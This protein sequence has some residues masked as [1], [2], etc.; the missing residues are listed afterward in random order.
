MQQAPALPTIY[1]ID[2]SVAVTGAFV[3][4][5]N[6]AR[7]LKD[8]ARVV[9]VL[10]E[11]TLITRAECCDFWRVEHI[12]AASL[13]KNPAAL[14]RYLPNVLRGGL[15]VGRLMRNDTSAHLI[16]ND[17]YVMQGIVLRLLGYR[18][19]IV[20]L[21]RCDPR[22]FAGALAPWMLWMQ[23]ISADRV[24]AVS[25]HVRSLLPARVKASV[26]YDYFS[27]SVR[28]PVKHTT[29]GEKRFVYIGNYIA[30]KGQDMAL[31]AFAMVAKNDPSLSLH[32]YGGDMGLAKNR[33]YRLVL[34]ARAH[35]VGLSARIHFHDFVAD[36][37]A[38]L[39]TGFAALNFSTSESFSMTVLEASGCGL[40]V[41][42]TLS[43]GPQEILIEGKTGYLIPVGDVSAAARAIEMLAADPKN[44]FAM[45]QAGAEHVTRNFSRDHFA[46]SLRELLDF[47]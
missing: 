10:P 40:P 23:H 13:S 31:E 37:S 12:P 6:I 18:G 11:Q 41:V 32:F 5:R 9:L 35:A 17:F 36:T 42:A 47:S 1:V 7:A 30:G 33:S 39:A 8:H 38:L 24:V 21:V 26:L 19:K 16:L 25:Q 46:Q 20:S 28:A 3:A 14:L 44:A 22:R 4:A 45:G 27:G 34:E 15:R 2:P 29:Q 43:G